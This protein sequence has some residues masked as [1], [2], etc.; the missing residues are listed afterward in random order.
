MKD[1]KV[2]LQDPDTA[3]LNT[4]T[5][6]DLSLL[7]DKFQANSRLAELPTSLPPRAGP[8]IP[9]QPSHPAPSSL[10]AQIGTKI[11]DN[12]LGKSYISKENID[13]FLPDPQEAPAN[14]YGESHNID[15]ESNLDSSPNIGLNR[16]LDLKLSRLYINKINLIL[17]LK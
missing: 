10:Q 12:L 1:P 9:R 7:D 17:D 15:N 8:S 6:I 2:T 16:L 4:A 14:N 3:T 11:D 5:K 13:D